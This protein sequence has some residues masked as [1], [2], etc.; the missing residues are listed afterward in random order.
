MKTIKA[1]VHRLPTEN[2]TSIVLFPHHDINQLQCYKTKGI[3]DKGVGQHLYF[4]TDEEI[5]GDW[6][7]DIENKRVYQCEFSK[8]KTS[9]NRDFNCFRKI[10]A[11][12][13]PELYTE[14]DNGFEKSTKRVKTHLPQPTQA[15]IKA[16]CKQGG[17]DEVDVEYVTQEVR[18]LKG[19]TDL[20]METETKLKLD[21]IHNTI[22][23]HP[24]ETDFKLNRNKLLKLVHDVGGALTKEDSTGFDLDKWIEENL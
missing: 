17:I 14:I 6:Y 19:G 10:I 13:D 22:I 1:K 18:V 9:I 16:Y 5:K 3:A 11:T 2:E 23:I 8:E 12:T 4:T 20:C 15:F 24:V 21:P 7:L